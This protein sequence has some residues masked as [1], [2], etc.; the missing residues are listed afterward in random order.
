MK[1]RFFGHS[2]FEIKTDD[3]HTILIDPYLDGNPVAT[4]GSDKVEADFIVPTHAHGDHLGDT[5]KIAER[6]GSLVICVAE[7]AGYL[8]GK[9]LKTHAMQVGGA[10]EF[11]FGKLKFT[12]AWH[13]SMTPDGHYAGPA[14]GVLLWIDDVCVYHAGDTG[15]FYDMRLIGEMHDVDYMMVPIGDNY[16]MG[17]DDAV[18][19]VE[20]VQPKNVIPM[21]YNTWP[22]IK[23]DPQLFASKIEAMGI[24]CLLLSP[25]D[26]A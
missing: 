8:S 7:L 2:A 6:C 23:A 3:G 25:G 14:A 5:I 20:Y 21:H 19:A 24:K 17:I 12:P 13:G 11:P 9:G 16:T 26:T 18:R 1:L 4:V 22:V 10:H 15:L